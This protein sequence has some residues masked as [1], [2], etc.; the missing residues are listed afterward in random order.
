MKVVKMEQIEKRYT[1]LL[2]EFLKKGYW[3]YTKAC[4]GCQG[5]LAKVDVTNGERT[6]RIRMES[7]Y[8]RRFDVR[9]K[10]GDLFY[11]EGVEIIVEE[12]EDAHADS[13]WN[14][15]GVLVNKVI[16]H[17]IGHGRPAYTENLTDSVEAYDKHMD[18][19]RAR[20]FSFSDWKEVNFNPDVVIRIVTAKKGFKSC[21]KTD[22]TRVEKCDSMYRISIGN[23]GKCVPVYFPKH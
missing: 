17:R 22:I 23:K 6:F 21:K 16:F 18:R 5:E 20:G 14:G 12:F 1:E 10:D 3:L 13:F 2:G 7:F 19:R 15:K 4:K 9:D 8:N 11:G